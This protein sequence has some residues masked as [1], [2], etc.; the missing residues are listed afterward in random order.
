MPKILVIDDDRT[1]RFQVRRSLEKIDCAVVE[2]ETAQAGIESF[3]EERPDAVLLDISLPKRSGLEVF[4][5]LRELDRKTPIIFV[6]AERDSSTAIQAMQLG[7]FDYVVKPVNL[8]E[9]NA[10]V[11]DAI[12]SK[13]LMNIPVAIE[14]SDDLLVSDGEVLVGSSLPMLEVFKQIGRMAGQNVTV[15]VRGESGTGKELVARSLYMHST[16]SDE[17]FVA[18]NCAAIPDQL[19]ES[20]LFGHEKGAF[21]GADTTRIGRFEQCNGGTIFLDEIGDM[22]PLVQGKVLRLLQ[23]QRFERVGGNETIQTDV[24]II[25]ATNRNL[26]KMV[27]NGE[28]RSDLFYRLNGLTIS[29]PALRERDGDLE[30]L[31][32]YF[33]SKQRVE[34]GKTDVEGVSPQALDAMKKYSWPGNIRELQSVVR[35]SLINTTGTV[36]TPDSLPGHLTGRDELPESVRESD[37]NQS[38]VLDSFIDH[39]LANGSNDLYRETLDLMEKLLLTKVLEATNGNQSK[40]AEILGIT[41]A[42]IRDRVVSFGLKLDKSVAISSDKKD[43]T[44]NDSG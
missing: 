1:I 28:Y 8:P 21:T 3:A 15:L 35:Q 12:N 23:E 37:S 31:L 13:R 33:F 16:R 27:A 34:L 20:E 32:K 41:R 14:A 6:T 22:T 11:L 7:A 5:D 39:R 24:R 9:L 17:S 19:L 42:K 26:E 43:N 36:I 4:S 2:A 10:L 44:Q 25:A 40:A 30:S 38:S 29:L 18:V